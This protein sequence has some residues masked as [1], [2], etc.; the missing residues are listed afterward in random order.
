MQSWRSEKYPECFSWVDSYKMPPRRCV[1]QDCDRVSNKELGISIH[2]SPRS[3]K[4]RVKWKRFVLQH[5]KNFNP[6]GSFG[7]CSLHFTS[8][9]FTRAVHIKG[10]ERRVK[11]GSVPTIWKEASVSLSER[12]RRTVREFAEF[13]ARICHFAVIFT[14]Q[15]KHTH[16]HLQ[17]IFFITRLSVFSFRLGE[18]VMFIY[19]SIYVARFH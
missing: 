16:T 6:K 10:T 14:N 15:G 5:R 12:S 11:A 8:D 7:V 19:N 2:E 1:V 17:P 18:F 4:E 9:C 3:F 13:F